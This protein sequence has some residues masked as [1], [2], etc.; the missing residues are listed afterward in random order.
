MLEKFL[1]VSPPQKGLAQ[2]S[3]AVENKALHADFKKDFDQKLK[4]KMKEQLADQKPKDSKENK[5]GPKESKDELKA[6]VKAKKPSGGTKKKMV[7]NELDNTTV[8]KVMASIENE[9]EITDQRTDQAPVEENSSAE[10]ISATAQ[11]INDPKAFERAFASEGLAANKK[12]EDLNQVQADLKSSVYAAGTTVPGVEAVQAASQSNVSGAF[13]MP[14]QARSI[15]SDV[16][17]QMAQLMKQQSA[18]SLSDASPQN[19]SAT[20][21]DQIKNLLAQMN[22]S[23]QASGA[24]VADAASMMS[25]GQQVNG[26]AQM[27][28]SGLAAGMGL[29]DMKTQGQSA[30]DTFE[31]DQGLENF[32]DLSE[33]PNEDLKQIQNQMLAQASEKSALSQQANATDQQM[34]FDQQLE[35]EVG[36][37]PLHESNHEI[38]KSDL[39]KAL[40]NFEAEKGMS[41]EKANAFELKVLAQ[42]RQEN[43]FSQGKSSGQQKGFESGKEDLNPELK[44]LKA[45]A[46]KPDAMMHAGQVQADFRGHLATRAENVAAPMSLAQL[47]EHREENINQLMKQTQFLAAK[48]GGEMTVKMSPD[49]M[50]PIQLKVLMQD[51]KVSIEMQ[52][53][54]K[55]V[56]KLIEDSLTELKSG[57]ASQRIHIDHVKIDTV[58]ATNAENSA[59]FNSDRNPGDSQGRQ[60]EFWKQ[61]RENFG[62]QSRKNSYNDVQAAPA[63]QA[64]A[65]A[66]LKPITSSA[67]RQ[68]GRTGS[69]INRVA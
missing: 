10:N 55:S 4:E 39:V 35:A 52:T 53:Q 32:S 15:S 23:A 56:K 17:S 49:G 58:H 48:G 25:D 44:S 13:A 62:N 42:L 22:S 46:L 26:S 27:M 8:S 29:L 45:D 14:A 30:E 61:F 1:A 60:Q 54:D 41:A 34:T 50:G 12:S 43:S 64:N 3:K 37:E 36:F 33:V 57:L 11:N 2:D 69:T 7:D 19:N 6:E 40:K 5:S 63:R 9:V 18:A 20:N 24:K 68:T 38:S 51:G 16:S 47:Q 66:P 31:F 28:A 59:Q 65:P 21:L 67:A